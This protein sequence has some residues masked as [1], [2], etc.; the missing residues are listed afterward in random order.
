MHSTLSRARLLTR[1]LAVL[2]AV[3]VTFSATAVYADPSG[4]K[5][6][7]DRQATAAADQ[8]E[9]A[10]D[11]ARQAVVDLTKANAELPAVQNAVQEARGKVAGAETAA[12]QAERE[13]ETARQG[14][15]AAAADYD[16]AAASVTR[17]RGRAAKF[18]V[19]AY[20]GSSFSMV[21]SIID[22]QSP[23]D[24]A[25]AMAYLNRIAA[26]QHT[27]LNEMTAARTVAIQ[28]SDAADAARLGAE[29]AAGEAKAALD[30]AVAA[31]A[32]AERSEATLTAL[33]ASKAQ[34]AAQA[35]AERGAVLARY[36]QLRQE[37]DRIAAELRSAATR[38]AAAHS[39][40]NIAGGGTG[41]FLMP[42][43]GRKSSDYGMR[44]DPYYG[45][46]QLHAGTDFAAGTGT[47]I[48][49]ADDG[50]IVRAGPSNGYGNYTCVYHGMYNGKELS[51]CYGHQSRIDV[52]VGE[53]VDRGQPIGLVGNTGAST[54]S[55][56]HFE[57][58]LDGAPVDP[59]SW[60]PSCLC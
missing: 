4:D 52:V 9:D 10:T 60:L 34:A 33:I 22:A 55:H 25:V 44:L 43:V 6:D 17:A 28:R 19:A 12:R 2:A 7:I 18:A 57:V 46:T 31:K 42:V 54:G 41:Y 58:R 11:R 56:L 26:T 40:K 53:H 14:A 27:A 8:L 36:S 20:Q 38:A 50:E 23:S 29:K 1:S 3:M 59:L 37:S 13:A 51:T 24:L 30:Q 21:N 48:R 35:E 47:V 16:V 5:G 49:A 39:N 45:V 32:E 15:D